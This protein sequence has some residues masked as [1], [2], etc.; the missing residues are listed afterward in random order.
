MIQVIADHLRNKYNNIPNL[1][2][3]NDGLNGIGITYKYYYIISLWF[4]RYKPNIIC[5]SLYSFVVSYAHE[6]Y[7][8][9]ISDPE[10]IS[11]MEKYIE[12]HV[13]YTKLYV[14]QKRSKEI[15]FI[16]NYFKDK[17]PSLTISINNSDYPGTIFSWSNGVISFKYK[18]SY[19]A[20]IWLESENIIDLYLYD[21]NDNVFSYYQGHINNPK[22]IEEIEKHIEKHI[23]N[24]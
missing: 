16:I 9:D 5:L 3:D 7:L 19:I 14:K 2:I 15:E 6:Q 17:Y 20:R 11:K 10:S 18:S 24:E 22:Y 21:N 4:M 1:S 23:N 13:D 8:F 12:K